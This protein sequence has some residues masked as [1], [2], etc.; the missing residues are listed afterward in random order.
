MNLATEQAQ[1][2][3]VNKAVFK[4]IQVNGDGRNSKIQLRSQGIRSTIK[5]LITECDDCTKEGGRVLKKL[6]N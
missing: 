3:K 1:N 6:D 5:S 2:K 4:N